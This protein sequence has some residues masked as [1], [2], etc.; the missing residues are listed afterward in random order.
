LIKHPE[1][2]VLSEKAEDL[3]LLKEGVTTKINYS[4]SGTQLVGTGSVI[5]FYD[6][7]SNLI[8]SYTVIVTGDLNGDGVVDALD[9]TAC[10]AYANELRAPTVIEAYAANGEADNTID[11]NSYQ[12]IVNLSLS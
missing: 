2:N 12:N 11:V 7:S 5:E 8:D 6:S 4:T 1:K 10:S 3:I 9:V